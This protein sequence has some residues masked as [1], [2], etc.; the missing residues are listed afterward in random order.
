MTFEAPNPA[1]APGTQSPQLWSRDGYWFGVYADAADSGI[2]CK[3]DRVS[4]AV[5]TFDLG[6][7]PGN[8]MALP[9]P[10]PADSHYG[11]A[12]AAVDGLG[13]I[14]IAGNGHSEPCHKIRSEFPMDISSWVDDAPDLS[15]FGTDDCTYHRFDAAPDGTLFWWLDLEESPGDS[16][17]RDII[18]LSRG[19]AA[20]D[21]TIRGELMK[22]VT[23]GD[24]LTVPNRVYLAGTRIV[25]DGTP[26][27]EMYAWGIWRMDDSNV[28]SQQQP[29][30]LRSSDGGDQW[31]PIGVDVILAD[32][33]SI[34]FEH[35]ISIFAEISADFFPGIGQSLAVVDGAPS[36]VMR[37]SS[38]EN[39]IY[40][41]DGDSWTHNAMVNP[42]AAVPTI[43][44]VNGRL[45]TLTTDNDAAAAGNRGRLRVR[46][47]DD[48]SE[49][50]L[51]HSATTGCN[52]LPDPIALRDEG[53]IAVLIPNGDDPVVY[54]VGGP[55]AYTS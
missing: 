49:F 27:G 39:R 5:E 2:V 35:D 55:A 21:W 36:L 16:R 51:G 22:S 40:T 4:G 17:G 20:T 42:G 26:E 28:A 30:L 31:K 38:D 7:I 37:H 29:F 23:P 54:T 15:A 3:I 47:L 9:I 8:P 11:F 34:S 44:D 50:Y 53:I 18:M 33:P 43:H 46:F 48:G 10:L 19:P 24:G 25:D 52:F 6:T 32:L 14:H 45:F 12:G 41:W 13:Y 1:S